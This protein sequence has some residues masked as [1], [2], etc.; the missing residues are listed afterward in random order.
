[1]LERRLLGRGVGE[2]GDHP[3]RLARRAPEHRVD[4]P[5]ALGGVALGQLDRLADR[6]VRR[7]A[8]EKGQLEDPEAQCGQHGRIELR[9]WPAGQALDHVVERRH[10]LDGPVA[11][12]GREPEIARVQPQ[13][14]GFA[15]QRAVGPRLLLEHAAHHG[16]RRGAG[17]G[18]GVTA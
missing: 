16:V 15:V 10:P 17:G 1:V 6:C 14:L 13:T 11:E 7:D 3:P 4:Q 12:L 2:R 9:G 18:D 8:V 5:G